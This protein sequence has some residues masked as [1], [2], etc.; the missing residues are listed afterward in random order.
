MADKLPHHPDPKFFEE[1]GRLCAAWAYLE[2]RTDSAIWGIL[3]IK[4]DTGQHITW[5]LDMR[6][7]W[8]MLMSIS[9]TLLTPD[10]RKTLLALNAHIEELNE[11]R[12]LFVHGAISGYS[13][14][15]GCTKSSSEERT[16]ESRNH[17]QPNWW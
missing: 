3:K 7:R 9:K 14:R 8:G 17:H 10:K 13:D 11:Q 15:P 1:L 6:G 4:K 16:K 5:R 2:L 12:N